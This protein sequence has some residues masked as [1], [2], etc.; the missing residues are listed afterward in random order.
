MK[1]L[2]TN[3]EEILT[4]YRYWI[5]S[6]RMRVLFDDQLDSAGGRPSPDDMV[7]EPYW[8]YWYGSLYVVIEGWKKLQ[9]SNAKIDGFLGSVNVDLLRVFRNGVF[10]YQTKWWDDKFL[11]F[12]TQGQDCVRWVREL[13]REFGRFFLQQFPRSAKGRATREHC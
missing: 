4:L 12:I 3:H 5:W 7:L 8:C 9:L 13:H 11:R 2:K 10:H 1:Q 6:D